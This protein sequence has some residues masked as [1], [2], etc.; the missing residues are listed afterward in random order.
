MNVVQ[1]RDDLLKAY[2]DFRK[3]ELTKAE[4]N[5]A[6]NAVGK[7]ISTAKCQLDYNKTLGEKRKINFLDVNEV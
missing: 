4:L 1:L 3:G 7:I 2:S 6:S 5:E